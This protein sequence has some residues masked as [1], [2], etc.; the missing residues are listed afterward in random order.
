[1]RDSIVST[2]NELCFGAN[3]GS[4]T[5]GV[6]GGTPPYTYSWNTAPVQTTTTANNLASG[7]YTFTVTDAN[8]CFVTAST[9]ITQPSRVRDSIS[10]SNN[11]L[12]FGG[13]TGSATVGVKNGTPGYTFSWNTVPIQ[14]TATA[15]GLS[16]GSY[17][18]TVT[19]AN[20]C[21]NVVNVIIV[22]PTQ[23]TMR[24]AAFPAAC[25]GQCNGSATALPKGGTTPYSYSWNT[26]P[27]ATN[28]NITGLCAS[29]YSIQVTDANAC[30]VDST[31]IT[32][33]QPPAISITKTGTVSAHCGQPD[34][35]GG[36]S[37]AGGNPPYSYKWSNSTSSTT[38][39]LNNVTPGSYCVTV[40]DANA[41][42]DTVCIVINDIPGETVSITSTTNDTCNGGADGT[43]TAGVTGNVG[44]Y[45]Y[46][47]NST[48]TQTTQMATGLKA[49]T[50][51]VTVTDSVGC[52]STAVATINQP[53]VVITTT[54]VPPP[55]CIGQPTTINA[56]SV[57]G[58][59]PYTYSWSNGATGS[60][61]TVSPPVTTTYSV[62][63]V[64]AY[65][66]SG[67]PI[68]TVV[69]IVDQPLAVT[70][71]SPVAICPG[72]TATLTAKGSGGDGNYV[73]TWTPGNTTG[74]SIQVTPAANSEYTVTLGDNCENFTVT[75]SVQVLID[76]T[77]VVKFT[78]DTALGCPG[79]CVKFTDGSTVPGGIKSWLWTFGNG[80]TSTS[81]NPT[82]CF[83]SA[84][85]F[86]VSLSV[87]SDSGCK[88]VLAVPKFVTIYSDPVAAFDY[89][90]QTTTN[91]S[92]IIT[93]T[94]QSTDIYGI[95]KYLWKFN[96]A[97]YNAE[98]TVKDTSYAYH[99]T[100]TFC[101][102]LY[103]T[104]KH[105][106][107]DSVQH[108]VV[109]NPFFTLYIPNAF[110]PN[111]D[112]KNDVFAPKANFVCDFQMYIFDRW[113]MLLYYTDDIKHGWDGTV[114]GGTNYVQEDTY[115]YIIKVVDCVEHNNHSYLGK[116]TVV[117]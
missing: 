87:V 26:V 64:D 33:T 34:G 98:A 107:V 115:I 58:T 31:P 102:I 55:I 59:T 68:T 12:C 14:T 79:Q 18:C 30:V 51:T 103:V 82:Y 117:N 10:I 11:V 86:T 49:G 100:G 91:V 67:N 37:V 96:E 66:C 48:P 42:T 90:P 84:G 70:T 27:P 97:P 62:T 35:S 77:P 85:L 69:V 20:G 104:N 7:S 47:W 38:A 94:N 46:S 113:G 41:C 80:A 39:N 45:T 57:G 40:T 2:V 109:I 74:A 3:T 50:Y 95:I 21:I 23:L 9:T 54:N 52:I 16:I 29:N 61:I 36:V 112:G 88:G 44:P 53:T 17:N 65:G 25:F 101:P 72:N 73:Y 76:P 32:V 15:T 110:S 83:D 92:P 56:T 114:N 24:A 116:V 6:K 43:A 19:D 5:G 99:D 106:C 105:K 111:G 4:A 8:S 22:Q 28:P 71:I 89:T 13:N 108:C 1:M 78:S 81:Q 93:F 63:T 60:S 75:D